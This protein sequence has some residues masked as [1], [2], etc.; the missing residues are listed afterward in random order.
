MELTSF[1]NGHT[2]CL[3]TGLKPQ[4]GTLK[5]EC[6]L[7]LNSYTSNSMFLGGFMSDP[8]SLRDSNTNWGYNGEDGSMMVKQ[9]PS[10]AA[11]SCP[12]GTVQVDVPFEMAG[13]YAAGNLSITIGGQTYTNTSG[14]AVLARDVWI[15]SDGSTNSGVG[16]FTL[17]WYKLYDGEILARDFVPVQ[18]I[19]DR[20][21]GLWDY[22]TETFYPW[23]S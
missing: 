23:Q 10:N 19:S 18:R 15:G 11:A 12:A 16:D 17:Y 8:Y 7:S 9:W 1:D 4:S 2:Y 20:V 3:N 5:F 14:A 6:K 21:Y 13:T 22:V